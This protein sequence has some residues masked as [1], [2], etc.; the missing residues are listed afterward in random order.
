MK[1]WKKIPLMF[2]L[3]LLIVFPTITASA[4][5]NL[6]PHQDIVRP[7]KLQPLLSIVTPAKLSFLQN[8]TTVM[9]VVQHTI[10]GCLFAQNGK[11]L[12]SNT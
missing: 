4:T 10:I 2:V 12:I 1:L 5:R 11:L 3:S 8:L 9:F 6:V 7:V